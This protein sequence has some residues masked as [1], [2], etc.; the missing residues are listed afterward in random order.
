LQT[1]IAYTLLFIWY[2]TQAYILAACLYVTGS[3]ATFLIFYRRIRRIFQ[4]VPAQE[5]SIQQPVTH[6]TLL[7]PAHNE[8]RLLPLLLASIQ[9]LRYPMALLHVAVIADNCTDA[10]AAI[11]RQAGF[12][13]LE[14]STQAP[15]DK[16]QALQFAAQQ[17]LVTSDVADTVVCII[18]ADSVLEPAFL[19]ELDKLY[20]R[21][22]AAPV[23][24]AFRSVSNAFASDVTVLDAAAEAL[25]QWVLAGS[26]K[27][28]GFDNFIFGLGCSMRGQ[29]FLELMQLPVVSL[30]EDKEWKVFLTQRNIRIDYCPTARLSYEVV[31]E[32]DAFGRQRN[33]WLAGYYNL[34]RT[35]GLPMLMQGIRQASFAKLDMACDLL[36]PPRSVLVLA[37]TGFCLLTFIFPQLGPLGYEVWLT[38]TLLF[39]GYAAIGLRLIGAPARAYLALFFSV[40]L[41]TMITKSMLSVVLGRGVNTWDAT[42]KEA[43]Q[44]L[45][46]AQ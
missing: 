13:S 1:I 10:T 30:A 37:A 8:A 15:S 7:V 17:A 19:T 23:V 35:H 4:P 45:P 12:S 16:M 2:A 27:V 3:A 22:G 26:R 33:R 14:R 41:L 36:Q 24:Q 38:I 34:L 6:F 28:L 39:L 5:S 11:A 40:R 20:A 9:K 18:D 32:A 29:V 44:A 25:R 31:E 46:K 21:S 42:R 43:P